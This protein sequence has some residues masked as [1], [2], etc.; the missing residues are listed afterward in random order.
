LALADPRVPAGQGTGGLC[1]RGGG[2]GELTSGWRAALAGTVLC[3]FR[4]GATSRKLVGRVVTGGRFS[5]FT[6]RFRA[7][8]PLGE[9]VPACLRDCDLGALP[10]N[11]GNGW[12]GAIMRRRQRRF[13]RAYGAKKERHRYST[14]AS[15]SDQMMARQLGH[16]DAAPLPG[17]DRDTDTRESLRLAPWITPAPIQY[18]I[19][20]IPPPPG[21]AEANSRRLA[22]SVS[23]ERVCP[24][25]GPG[26]AGQAG[27]QTKL[28]QKSVL[29]F[30]MGRMPAAWQRRLAA[31]E[32]ENNSIRLTGVREDRIAY[33]P[34]AEKYGAGSDPARRNAFGASQ[35]HQAELLS[36]SGS[37]P[38]VSLAFS[39][40][41]Q[42]AFGVVLAW[43][44]ER[45]QSLVS[46]FGNSRRAPRDLFP[47]FST[48]RTRI[49]KSG[50]D[51][52]MVAQQFHREFSWD[53]KTGDTSKGTW[54]AKPCLHNSMIVS[55]SG[56]S[57][58]NASHFL[59]FEKKKKK[60][61]NPAGS[62]SRAGGGP[63]G[64]LTLPAYVDLQGAA[65]ACN[66]VS[67]SGRPDGHDQAWRR[68]EETRTG[69]I[70][71]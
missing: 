34:K 5:S 22:S 10:P 3:L 29:D 28:G 56:K 11:A 66:T 41:L 30:V 64:F 71:I 54:T 53:P 21:P 35:P 4:N 33:P 31:H 47:Q 46:H 37:K 55:A 68:W 69:L 24:A 63:R 20:W 57:M 48:T 2:M 36:G 19:S 16:L 27:R 58:Q 44:H 32:K 52:S 18:K 39:D 50:E 26:R 60:K 62:C 15:P 67:E 43:A 17:V 38:V 49:A 42:R 14:W 61:T 23:L 65:P 25:E 1:C 8:K 13:C 40:R 59:L 7:G 70:S 12:R 6:P 45:G 51:R 9:F